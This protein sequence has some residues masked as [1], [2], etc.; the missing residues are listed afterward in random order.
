MKARI[1]LIVALSLFIMGITAFTGETSLV[2]GIEEVSSVKLSKVMDEDHLLRL[3]RAYEKR[4]NINYGISIP[5]GAKGAPVLESASENTTMAKSNDYSETNTQVTGVD[6]G[7]VIKT[8]GEYIYHLQYNKVNVYRAYPADQLSFSSSIVFG[9]DF[10]FQEMFLHDDQLIVIG[11]K[12][13]NINQINYPDILSKSIENS[14][15]PPYHNYKNFTK[16]IVMDRKTKNYNVIKEFEIE[17]NYFSSRKLNDN[18]YMVSNKQIYTYMPMVKEF[19][20]KFEYTEKQVIEPPYFKEDNEELRKI[21]VQD[22]YYFPN[23]STPEFMTVSTINLKDLSRDVHLETYIGA[24]HS[25]YV[26]TENL[27]IAN[28]KYRETTL[29]NRNASYKAKTEIHKIKLEDGKT[30]YMG[31]GMVDGRILNQ[32]SMDEKDNYFRIATTTGETWRND[33]FASKNHL[34]ILD[35]NL[36]IVGSINNIAPTERIYSMRFMGDKAY[37]VT[38]RETDPFYV[39]DL[40]NPTDPK[41]LGYL[42]IPGYSNYLHPY[43]ENHIIGFGKEVYETKQGFIEGGMK[44]A[45]FDV[46]DVAN[47]TEKHKVEIGGRGTYSEL[48]YNHKALLFD[49]DRNLLSFPITVYSEE[50]SPN[51]FWVG[52]FEFQGAYV[53]H[54]DMENGFDLKGRITHL[55]AD[56]HKGIANYYYYGDKNIQRVLRIEDVLYTVSGEMVKANRLGDLSEI[57]QIRFR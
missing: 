6:E 51:N 40:K 4:N 31:S 29:M 23:F 45:V 55:T 3:V 10:Y 16:V 42:K 39:I 52:N 57:R 12:Q 37:M 1:I 21:A 36:K 9:D 41:I 34:F 25:I 47:P 28:T 14:L 44:I 53:Y 5:F 8:D 13:T 17:G 22:I 24:S 2:G 32:F 20:G 56:D 30:T 43:D 7:D 27:Y 33:E 38:F 46:T 19:N 48:L 54:L 11:N 35:K 15:M 18:L 49:R 50:A 26:S